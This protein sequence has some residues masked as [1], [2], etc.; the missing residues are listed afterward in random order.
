MNNANDQFDIFLQGLLQILLV[1][2]LTRGMA[3]LPR[4]SS[5]SNMSQR[6]SRSQ[7]SS[8]SQRS[9]QTSRRSS[10]SHSSLSLAEIEAARVR[11]HTKSNLLGIG[12]ALKHYLTK[13]R[14]ILHDANDSDEPDKIDLD[15]ESIDVAA[16]SAEIV[17]S[18][19]ER[20]Q[21]M[22]DTDDVEVVDSSDVDIATG[23]PEATG[24]V[25][26]FGG[27]YELI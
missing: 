17:N 7:M 8:R 27:T 4:T 25:C 21:L 12:Q 1:F 9:S 10:R 15:A 16:A 13:A 22:L 20:S 2:V 19:L 3:G 5:S 18:V 6:S 14:K 26:F 11:D 23:Q 24:N